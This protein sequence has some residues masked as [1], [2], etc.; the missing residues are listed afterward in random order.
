MQQFLEES[1]W[2]VLCVDKS[3]GGHLSFSLIKE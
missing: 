3:V 1:P 2:R